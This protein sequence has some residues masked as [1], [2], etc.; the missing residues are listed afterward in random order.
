MVLNVMARNWDLI[1]KALLFA[2]LGFLIGIASTVFYL[3]IDVDLSRFDGL[4]I[5]TA[6]L[7]VITSFYA[8]TTYEILDEQRKSRQIALSEKKLK[9]YSQLEYA[10]R[11]IIR[12][13]NYAEY[14]YEEEQ[15]SALIIALKDIHK[16]FFLTESEE[17]EL[18]NDLYRLIYL[19]KLSGRESV[20]MEPSDIWGE[21]VELIPKIRKS[22]K[23]EI[24]E[25]NNILN[26]SN[27]S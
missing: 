23:K 9:F 1:F 19:Y 4:Q 20:M 14:Q 17:S 5:L 21:I 13:E 16:Y 15:V 26:E 6:V 2:F 24:A 3:G 11:S 10:L 25:H 12:D 7:I 18:K 8:I 22:I 27:S